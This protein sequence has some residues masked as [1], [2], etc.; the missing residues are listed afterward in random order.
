RPRRARPV[1]RA[2]FS[3]ACQSGTEQAATAPTQNEPC[4]RSIQQTPSQ[5]ILSLSFKQTFPNPKGLLPNGY[6]LPPPTRRYEATC[7]AEAA[8]F[9]VA[10]ATRIQVKLRWFSQSLELFCEPT[11]L[12]TVA[13]T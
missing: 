13:L 8:A 1:T 7:E 12:T 9:I 2:A 10:Q 6:A 5:R 3:I 11:L 4:N